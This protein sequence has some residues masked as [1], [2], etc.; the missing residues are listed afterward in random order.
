MNAHSVSK[1][2]LQKMAYMILGIQWENVCI[3]FWINFSVCKLQEGEYLI[4]FVVFGKKP[5]THKSDGERFLDFWNRANKG[6]LYPIPPA[7]Q[8]THPYAALCDCKERINFLQT[9][10]KRYWRMGTLIFGQKR[11]RG[12]QDTVDCTMQRTA[13][14]ISLTR[15]PLRSYS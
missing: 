15:S 4:S 11:A 6:T 2:R 3:G 10:G 13:A 14:K 8:P 5:P 7:P 1:P 9:Y 12:S